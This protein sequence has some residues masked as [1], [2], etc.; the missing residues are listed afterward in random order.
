[1]LVGALVAHHAYGAYGGEQH[2][3]RLPDVIVEP[4]LAQATDIDVVGLLEYAHLLGRDVAQDADG[5][6]R[7]GEG[8]PGDEMLG[9]AQLTAHAAHLVLEEPL[10]G[11]AELQVHLLGQTAHV[12]MALDHLARDV[13]TLYAVG[14]DGALGK[15]AGIGYLA[16]L[17][18]EHLHKVAADDLALLLWVCNSRQVGE[19]LLAGIH[20]YHVQPQH[21]IVVHHL[22]ELILAQHAVIHKD[23]R[24]TAADGPVEQYGSYRT[25]YAAGE[26]EDDAILAQL[27]LQLGHGGIHKRGRA[28]LLARAADV[29]HEVLQQ[30]SALKRMEHL[31]VELY[32]PDASGTPESSIRHILGAADDLEIVG[33]AGDGIAMRHPYLRLLFEALEKGVR[34]IYRLEVGAPILAAVC[35]LHT[36]SKGM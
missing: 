24:Q 5:K 13:Q 19:E 22:A 4:P 12:V 32:G 27:L 28:P 26:S 21:L 10:Q 2:D 35:L 17:G 20:A 16:S 9:H 36:A 31:G 18:V 7:S 15:P 8:M 11:L 6:S 14:I 33:D 29:Y 34:G 23:T 25:V 3:A 1:M 30:Q